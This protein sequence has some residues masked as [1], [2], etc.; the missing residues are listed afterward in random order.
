MEKRSDESKL[1]GSAPTS[2]QIRIAVDQGKSKDKVAFPD[3]AAAPLGTDDEAGGTPPTPE[4]LALER[5]QQKSSLFSKD[6]RRPDTALTLILTA[7]FAALG[8]AVLYSYFHD[9]IF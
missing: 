3:P 5:T 2:E 4:R 6:V 1:L 7:F 9:W 8:S